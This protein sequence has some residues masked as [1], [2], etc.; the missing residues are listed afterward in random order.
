MYYYRCRKCNKNEV[1][2]NS[3]ETADEEFEMEYD[4]EEDDM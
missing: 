4:S 3:I 1:M 2:D